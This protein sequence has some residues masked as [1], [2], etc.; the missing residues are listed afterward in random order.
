MKLPF[1][2]I[3]VA[4]G[5]GVV[6]EKYLGHF[7][8]FFAWPLFLLGL[9]WLWRFRKGKIFL[10]SFILLLGILGY[11]RAD[12]AHRELPDAVHHFLESRD[13]READKP[14][15][16]FGTVSSQPELKKR[17]RKVTLSFI[18][19]VSKIRYKK[20]SGNVQV[21]LFQ[22]P[23]IPKWGDHLRLW[24]SLEKPRTAANPGEFDYPDYLKRLNIHSIFRGYGRSIR[25]LEKSSN[26]WLSFAFQA[27]DAIMR[28][29]EKMFKSDARAVFKALNTGSQKEI[30]DNLRDDFMKT[31]TTHLLAV[32]G[33]NITLVVGSF[34]CLFLFLGVP[35]KIS[36][37]ISLLLVA[38]Y[39]VIAGFGAPV[40]RAA[41]MSGCA[42]FAVLLERERSTF[43][44]LCFSFFVLILVSPDTIYQIGF[45]LSFLSVAGLMLFSVKWS[46]GFSW[47]EGFQSTLAATIA[48]TPLILYY[49]HVISQISIV[50]N[51]FAIPIFHLA[52]MFSLLAL[53]GFWIPW[54]GM[55]MVS[56]ATGVLEAGLGW[57]HL[58]AKWRWGY[59]YFPAPTIPHILIYYG[60]LVGIIFLWR[61]GEEEQGRAPWF[62]KFRR[63]ILGLLCCA[64]MVVTG[65]FFWKQHSGEGVQW[66][67]FSAG[68]NEMIALQVQKSSWV[69][70]TGR[71]FPSSQSRWI[72]EPYLR[73]RGIRTIQS[74]ILSDFYRKHWGGLSSLS[75]NFEIKN[76]FY[77]ETTERKWG[78]R[79]DHIPASIMKRELT[80]GDSFDLG[81]DVSLRVL[82]NIHEKVVMDLT[83]RDQKLLLLPEMDDQG[84]EDLLQKLGDYPLD[85]IYL[86]SRGNY[87]EQAFKRLLEKF[88]PRKVITPSGSEN[89]E[90][91]CR[92]YDKVR[93]IDLS[94]EGANLDFGRGNGS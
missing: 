80:V 55:F 35:Q 77:P 38:V 83:V 84:A 21:F 59:G 18:L 36:A 82:Q 61:Q 27:R 39:T 78:E 31:G 85:M 63:W 4:F 24:G 46:D 9:P 76:V 73:S 49:F 34:F 25:I 10:P 16:L 52:Q 48:T 91:I 93:W 30:S 87:S 28:Q 20:V 69:I 8:V 32:S 92:R 23:E 50:A 15:T 5:A 51:L 75:R 70:H 88:H 44:A 13:F 81:E 72:L 65:L 37:L 45:Q 11:L 56:V 66:T 42:F 3:A 33:L 2:W 53:M 62:R 74:V 26:P 6:A 58:C 94:R 29:T 67:F 7:G 89:L 79:I 86:F 64:W 43:N 41:W 57:I 12:L 40:L 47:L 60:L 90:R 14:V 71:D 54:V 19:E 22:P 17:G 68:Q 1:L